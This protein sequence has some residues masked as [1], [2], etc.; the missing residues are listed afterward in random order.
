MVNFNI[1][2]CLKFCNFMDVFQTMFII[3][4]KWNSLNLTNILEY[5]I[6]V[7][8]N[9]LILLNSVITSTSEKVMAKPNAESNGTLILSRTII[10]SGY[11]EINIESDINSYLKSNLN[12]IATGF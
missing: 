1:V 9:K 3:I 6:Y 10:I 2:Y 4:I 5:P 8:C 7:L 12:Y 11:F